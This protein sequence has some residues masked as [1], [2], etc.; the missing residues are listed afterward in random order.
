MRESGTG[1]CITEPTTF[2]QNRGVDCDQEDLLES[3][4]GGKFEEGTNFDLTE[5][6]SQPCIP[7]EK[8]D[9]EEEV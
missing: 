5:G 3:S 7:G 4:P 9:D 8:D 1:V 2:E 6:D